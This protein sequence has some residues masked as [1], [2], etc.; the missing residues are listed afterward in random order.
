M[1]RQTYSR[2]TARTSNQTEALRL[3]QSATS[4]RY[5]STHIF[6]VVVVIIDAGTTN[7]WRNFIQIP[8]QKVEKHLQCSEGYLFLI[9]Q[10]YQQ[11]QSGGYSICISNQILRTTSVQMLTVTTIVISINKSIISIN[12]YTYQSYLMISNCRLCFTR[13]NPEPHRWS[14]DSLNINAEVE[15]SLMA[16]SVTMKTTHKYHKTVVKQ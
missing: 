11:P 9:S 15:I 4:A 5:K 13:T 6:L 1:G 8:R 14:R 10:S 12:Y 2:F 7:A 16:S 3:G